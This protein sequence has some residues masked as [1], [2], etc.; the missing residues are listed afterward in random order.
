MKLIV[1]LILI[2]LGCTKKHHFV[3][4]DGYYEDLY[5]CYVYPSEFRRDF[6]SHDVDGAEAQAEYFTKI[7]IPTT[8]M[9]KCSKSENQ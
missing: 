8:D 3:Y 6:T 4:S 5:I 2:S 9:I 7:Y 1:L